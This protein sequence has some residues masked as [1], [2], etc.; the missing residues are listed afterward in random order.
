MRRFGALF[1]LPVILIEPLIYPIYG[2][3]SQWAFGLVVVWGIWMMDSYQTF[4]EQLTQVLDTVIQ[5]ARFTNQAPTNMR[6]YMLT[7]IMYLDLMHQDV[8]PHIHVRTILSFQE[9]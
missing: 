9:D 2:N 3:A 5:V 4:T 8:H 7:Q 1:F 6:D